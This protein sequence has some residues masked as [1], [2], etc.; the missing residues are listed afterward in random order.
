MYLMFL[1]YVWDWIVL[2]NRAH[3]LQYTKEATNTVKDKNIESEAFQGGGLA[4]GENLVCVCEIYVD[5]CMERENL[6]L[7]ISQVTGWGRVG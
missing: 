4:A 2:M 3:H 5:T 7:S 1:L 6:H